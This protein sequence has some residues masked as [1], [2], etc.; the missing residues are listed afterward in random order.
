[1]NEK[2]TK[3]EIENTPAGQKMNAWIA[4]Y[5]MGYEWIQA[6][7]FDYDGPLPEQGLV[8]APSRCKG[9][10]YRWPPRGVIAPYAF[11]NGQDCHWSSRFELISD[12]I[13]KLKQRRFYIDLFLNEHLNYAI[14][15]KGIKKYSGKA[16]ESI[17][18]A[19]CRAALLAVL[20]VEG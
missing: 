20:E 15:H 18:L 2:P 12:L 13:E 7:K 14:V 8:L 1:M 17:V 6:P 16:K 10:D 19:L 5:L 11:I 9:D 4:E 3:Q